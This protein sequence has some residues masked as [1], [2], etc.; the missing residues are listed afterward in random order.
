M[1]TFLAVVHVVTSIIMVIFIL[2]QDPKG[3]GAFGMLGGG[4]SKSL[5]GSSGANQFLITVTKWTAIIFAFTSIYLAALSSQKNTSVIDQYTTESAE[6][7]PS[8]DKTSVE[9]PRKEKQPDGAK[10]PAVEKQATKNQPSTAV[11]TP[12]SKKD[13]VLDKATKQD[14]IQLKQKAKP[15]DM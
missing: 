10:K 12:S 8:A 9:T 4:G 3:G 1:F 5:F 13:T 2:L 6:K 15:K 11:S 14:K 7:T